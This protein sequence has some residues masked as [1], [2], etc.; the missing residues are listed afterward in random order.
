MVCVCGE[1][2]TFVYKHP[3]QR[4]K[5][6]QKSVKRTGTV[7]NNSSSASTG[8][9]TFDYTMNKQQKKVC[10]LKRYVIFCQQL[11]EQSMLLLYT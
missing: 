1:Q 8:S 11:P 2:M 6:G 4:V 9:V 10:L 7:S 5:A 3:E